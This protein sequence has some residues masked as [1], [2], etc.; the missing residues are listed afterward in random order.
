[1]F[2]HLVEPAYQGMRTHILAQLAS[3]KL[4]EDSD[5][6][7]ALDSLEVVELTMEAEEC[8][9]EPT[10]EIKNVKDF[11][12]LCRAMDFHRHRRRDNS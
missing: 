9:V 5:L 8:G 7:K 2:K 12:W 11:L 1:M 6:S 10:V 4:T 3:G